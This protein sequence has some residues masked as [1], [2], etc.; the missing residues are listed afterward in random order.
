MA[1]SANVATPNRS[2]KSGTLNLGSYATGGVAVNAAT[3]GHPSTLERV[4]VA[5]AA[6]FVFEYVPATGKVKAYNPYGLGEAM[7]EVA[8][9]TNL[10]AINAPFKSSG[11]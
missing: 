3:F 10:G 6:G 2:K 11:Y 1:A 9:A 7:T 8:N 5:P 4:H